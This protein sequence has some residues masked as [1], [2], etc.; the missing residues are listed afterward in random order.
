MKKL[1]LFAGILLFVSF[2]ALGQEKEADKGV[3]EI[4]E[5]Y[6]HAIGG[7][8]NLAKVKSW[9]FTGAM[10]M[11]DINAP[12]S[13]F[14][15]GNDLKTEINVLGQ[16]IIMVDSEKGSWMLN[17]F[18]KNKPEKTSGHFFIAPTDFGKFIFL[19]GLIQRM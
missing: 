19:N 4:I 16:K 8:D 2:A 14:S 15:K 5:R 18:E 10:K 13:V 6:I 11:K 1:L 17:P 9:K 12:V 3:L 7:R